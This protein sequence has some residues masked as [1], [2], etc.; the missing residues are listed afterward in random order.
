MGDVPETNLVLGA[1][2]SPEDLHT[3]Y[4]AWKWEFAAIPL[5]VTTGR[6]VANGRY[7]PSLAG[8]KEF[9]DFYWAETRHPDFVLPALEWGCKWADC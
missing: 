5:D 1:F 7:W 4:A 3:R 8:R 2:P 9:N 6:F